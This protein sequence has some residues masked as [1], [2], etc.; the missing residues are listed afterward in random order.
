MSFDTSRFTFDPGKDY[1]GVVMEQGRVQLD[2]DWN[3]WLAESARRIQAGTLDVVGRTGVPATTPFAFQ[4]TA[5]TDATGSHI[6]IGAGRIYVDGLLAENHGLSVSWQPFSEGPAAGVQWDPALG[7]MSG[8]PQVPSAAA[9]TVDYTKQPYLPGAALPSGKG[10][11]LVYLDVW[12]REVT[13]L[14]DPDLVDKAV[15]VDTTG[16]LQT[17]WQ[18]KLVD[19]SAVTGVTCATPDSSLPP[20][21]QTLIQPSAGQ[22][23][24]GVLQS[25][26]A[27]PC[28]LTSNTGYTG[29]ENQSYR[30]EI[31]Q[32]GQ[33]LP[34]GTATPVTSIPSGTATFKWSRDNASIAT[35]VTGIASVTNTAGNPASQLAVE[36]LGRD[37]VLGFAPGNW[38]EITDDW[39]ELNGQPGELHQIDS[40]DFTAQTITL[41]STVSAASY[42]T[43]SGATDPSRYTRLTRW[44]QSGKVLQSD[45][46]VWWELK[47]AGRGD[48]P[49]PPAN[50]TLVLENG[51]TVAFGLNPAS[52]SFHGG[53]LWTFAARTADGS[54]DL[55]TQAFPAGIQHHYCR[56]AIVSFDGA[57]WSSLHDCRVLFPTLT[58]PAIHVAAISWPNDDVFTDLFTK[59]LQ[60]TFDAPVDPNSFTLPGATVAGSFGSSTFVVTLEGPV[61][62]ANPAAWSSFVLAGSLSLAS[63]VVTWNP[64]I[65][66]T[67]LSQ[68]ASLAAQVRVRVT[69]KG[70]GIWSLGGNQQLYLDGQTFGKPSVRADGVTPRIFLPLP[71]GSGA[72]SSNF[73]SWFWLV[74]TA[75]PPKLA[76]SSVTLGPATV[77]EGGASTGTVTLNGT[78]PT[79]GATVTLS[80]S[81]LSVATVQ[82]SVVVLAGANTATFPVTGIGPGTANI[83]ATLDTSTATASLTV[84]GLAVANLTLSPSSVAAGDS[85]TGTVTLTGPAPG[86]FLGSIREAPLSLALPHAVLPATGA[87]PAGPAPAGGAVLGPTPAGGAVVG[88]AAAGGATV[89]L[90][91]SNS[92]WA[93]V[94]PSVVVPPGSTSAQFQIGTSS[95]LVGRSTVNITASF[96]GISQKA[97]LTI[98]GQ[99]IIRGN[100]VTTVGGKL[101]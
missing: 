68:F 4:I 65:S 59:G 30:V 40:I 77:V 87:V 48:I 81:N 20:S 23:T 83:Q 70:G 88:P 3:E 92:S 76:V 96:G 33:P 8:A 95:L 39:Q 25:A 35:A 54:V 47:A 101:V 75:A 2:S 45:G 74:A 69:L 13:S 56:L 24:T 98:F 15:G 60:V 55:L 34:T 19:V 57:T 91:S 16:R 29:M 21:W 73:E 43:T 58:A 79:G 6:T 84:A 52:G 62:A 80:S 99:L 97:A 64:G 100:G 17:V 1:C 14:E 82:A 27:G 78:A 32:P 10:N 85:L 93:T 49:L 36:S 44:D 26:P 9:V 41:D 7:E 11:F 38:V 72:A 94:P 5:F 22:L 31:H 67:F 53:D 63:N 42:P 12:R 51:I 50:T 37:Q 46:T 89:Q 86:A 61:S 18:V 28:C 90:S 71:S 66:Q